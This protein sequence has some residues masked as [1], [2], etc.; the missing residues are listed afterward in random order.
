MGA[1]YTT[2]DAYTSSNYF[3]YVYYAAV[4]QLVEQLI[5]NQ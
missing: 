3:V 4:A 1:K 5:S 2:L